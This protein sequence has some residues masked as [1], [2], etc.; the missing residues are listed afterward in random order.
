MRMGHVD[1]GPLVAHVDDA[2]AF[3]VQPHPDRHDV[4]AAQPKYPVHTALFEKARNH[5]CG[6]MY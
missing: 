2:D 5:R 6:R 4:P 1:G 3:G